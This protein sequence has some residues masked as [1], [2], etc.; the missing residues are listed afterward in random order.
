LGFAHKPGK[1]PKR[2]EPALTK[3]P[4]DSASFGHVIPLYSA[5]DLIDAQ[6]L[7]DALERA[8]IEV[9]IR[10]RYLQGAIGELP[11][12]VRP[13]V[14]VLRAADLARAEVIKAEFERRSENPVVGEERRCNVCGELSPPNFELCWSCSAAL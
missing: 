4:R 7:A 9:L 11:P 13:E 8:G 3:E 5:R 2:D 12:S 14:C 10:N 6:F 1:I